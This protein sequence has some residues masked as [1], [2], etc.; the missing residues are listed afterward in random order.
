[1][2]VESVQELQ[3]RIRALET[4]V[5][6]LRPERRSIRKRSTTIVLGLP[7]YDVAIGPSAERN[8]LRGH[9]RG[10]VAVGDIATGLLAVGG[11]ARGLVAVGGVSLGVIALGGCSLG[12]LLGFGGLSTGLLALGGLAIGGVAIGG[13]AI[14]YVSI[15]GGAIG[16]FACGGGAL[17]KYVLS[18]AE[19]NPEAV[20]FFR[21][22]IP[23]L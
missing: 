3:S 1:M 10:I 15:G 22:W 20:Q 13:G 8:E 11:V 5:E 16:Y 17:G 19:Q 6:R 23:G 21:N 7:L 2:A 18:A 4:E 9:A 12:L 14:G